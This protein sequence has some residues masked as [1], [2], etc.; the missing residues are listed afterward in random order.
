MDWR[1]VAFG[2]DPLS[3]FSIDKILI[4]QNYCSAV[5]ASESKVSPVPG[6][7]LVPT[8]V[9]LRYFQRAF[10]ASAYDLL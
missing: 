4:K 9:G 2:E 3:V 8:E 10:A 1:V 6:R 7:L 5:P